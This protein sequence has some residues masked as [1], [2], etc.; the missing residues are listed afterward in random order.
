VIA[1]RVRDDGR[2]HFQKVLADGGRAGDAGGHAEL[3]D[4]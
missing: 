2:W 4:Q 3:V 1:E